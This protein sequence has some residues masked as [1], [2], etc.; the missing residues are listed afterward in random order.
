V[1]EGYD[2][3]ETTAEAVLVVLFK[4]KISMTMGRESTVYTGLEEV[5]RRLRPVNPTIISVI[6][7]Y[8]IKKC[9]EASRSLQPINPTINDAIKMN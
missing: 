7:K 5:S 2:L 8:N 9:M 6:K 4:G 1:T 3:L